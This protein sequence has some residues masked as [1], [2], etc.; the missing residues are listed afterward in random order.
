M[1]FPY[2][3]LST[4]QKKRCLFGASLCNNVKK[5]TNK[6]DVGWMGI[7][8]SHLFMSLRPQPARIQNTNR[9]GAG[10][11][12]T[13][14]CFILPATLGQRR[15][16]EDRDCCSQK[17]TWSEAGRQP[18]TPATCLPSC[19][20]R[21]RY[22]Q[23]CV[24]SATPQISPSPDCVWPRKRHSTGILKWLL[25]AVSFWG[26]F[27]KCANKFHMSSFVLLSLGL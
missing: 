27:Y 25:V 21:W 17:S 6:N 20:E 9:K 16:Q 12:Q 22:Q 1:F 3:F 7:L 8:K 11:W 23:I 24:C 15:S 26:C 5:N 10:R 18:A 13:V 4:A 14:S 19:W 2:I